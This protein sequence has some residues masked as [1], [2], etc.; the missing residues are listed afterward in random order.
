MKEKPK[1]LERREQKSLNGDFSFLGPKEERDAKPTASAGQSG[2]AIKLPKT[3]QQFQREKNLK[4]DTTHLMKNSNLC[5]FKWHTN[6]YQCFCCKN[7]FTDIDDLKTHTQQHKWQEI[8]SQILKNNAVQ[9]HKVEITNLTCELCSEAQENIRVLKLHLSQRHQVNFKEEKDLLIPFIIKKDSFQC[10]ECLKTF[11]AF[12]SL[13]IHMNRHFQNHICETCGAAFIHDSNLKEHLH[14][15]EN[16]K[17]RCV[18]CK[19]EFESLYKK[20]MHDAS[21]H[22]KGNGNRQCPHCAE[23]FQCHYNRL[24]H[25]IKNHG[26][27]KP[28]F[29][30]QSCDRVFLRQYL[31]NSH[32][33]KFHM[34][35]KNHSCEVC[36][37]KFFTKYDLKQH[38]GTHGGNA[39]HVCSVCGKC[40][41]RKSSL[42]CHMKVHSGVV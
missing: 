19:T 9:Y 11:V 36:E 3:L 25:L 42:N 30:C 7:T 28:E 4:I 20:Q 17:Y 24:L 16:K 35:E 13:N 1:N 10:A 5:A 23:K 37:A 26:Y 31:L 27:K 14:R 22:K 6:K 34:K 29:K 40:Y 18:E 15:H 12:P 8:T 32:V 38:M 41:A 21:L 39:T 2:T 33:R